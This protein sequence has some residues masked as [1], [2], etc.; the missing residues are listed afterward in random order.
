MENKA[1]IDREDIEIILGIILKN[2]WLSY[3]LRKLTVIG[4]KPELKDK[5]KLEPEDIERLKKA[6]CYDFVFDCYDKAINKIC[7]ISEDD[8]PFKNMRSISE[9]G[10]CCFYLGVMNGFLMKDCG[11]DQQKIV[12]KLMQLEKKEEKKRQDCSDAGKKTPNE[13]FKQ[14]C[15]LQNKTKPKRSLRQKAIE[16]GMYYQNN[17]N[18]IIKDFPD[19][20]LTQTD[21]FQSIYDWL[22]DEFPE[23]IKR[24]RKKNK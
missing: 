9:V 3:E 18:Q 8:M 20:K 21:P 6:G 4:S 24:K 23:Q 13:P 10:C 1:E 22:K 5:Y 11:I 12:K 16:L 7:R 17:H 2:A 14:W 15:I 19:T